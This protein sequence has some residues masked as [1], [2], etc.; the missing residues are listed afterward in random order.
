M[1]VVNTFGPSTDITQSA[2][3]GFAISKSDTV[4]F[5]FITRAIWVGGAGDIAVVWTDDTTTILSA[6][7][8]G[9]LLPIGAKRINSTGTT[10]TL[11]VG[12]Y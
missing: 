9:A 11:M 7:S 8:A 2:V 3:G 10:A 12:L 1:T 5:S 4:N 6:V